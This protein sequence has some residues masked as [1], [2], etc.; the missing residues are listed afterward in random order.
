MAVY[1]TANTKRVASIAGNDLVQ[2]YQ[3]GTKQERTAFASGLSGGAGVLDIRNFAPVD[4]VVATGNAGADT[5]A[6]IAAL[7]AARASHLAGTPKAVYFPGGVYTLKQAYNQTGNGHTA[8]YIDRPLHI[9]GDFRRT[10]LLI[11]PDTFE[12]DVFPVANTFWVDVNGFNNYGTDSWVGPTTDALGFCLENIKIVGD[13]TSTTVQNGLVYYDRNFMSVVSNFECQYLH[14]TALWT[15]KSGGPTGTIGYLGESWFGNLRFHHCGTATQP[16]VDL[17]SYGAG[18]AT[19]NLR[20]Y[21]LEIFA[22]P[23]VH[24][25]IRNKSTGQRLTSL[26]FYGLRTEAFLPNFGTEVDA[27]LQIGDASYTTGFPPSEIYI[28]GF[29]GNACATGTPTIGFYGP[30]STRI[31]FDIMIEGAITSGAGNGI[32]IQAGRNICLRFSDIAVSG[33]DFI[34][35]SSTL[36]TGFIEYDL[37]GR[38]PGYTWDINSTA[39]GSIVFPRK[40]ARS[41]GNYTS[42]TPLTAVNETEIVTNIGAT[43]LVT[44]TLPPAVAGMRYEIANEVSSGTRITA[45]TGDFIRLGPNTAT[46]SGGH[47]DTTDLGAKVEIAAV[48]VTGWHAS[49]VIGNWTAT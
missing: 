23:N 40:T 31:P 5:A 8:S 19:N 47:I 39:N 18:I 37:I 29:K 38:P 32:D 10:I 45:A 26:F 24:L 15:G 9:Y 27:L 30:D 20:F 6:Y 16:A 42:D 14:G 17:N 7:N 22:A 35:G 12:G 25:A 4:T 48:S 44:Y 28:Y 21:D 3:V 34:V 36:V 2:I 13:K 43:A 1:E 11:E 46:A 49:S 33:T 41:V